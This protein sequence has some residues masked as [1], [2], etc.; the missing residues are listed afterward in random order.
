[1][2]YRQVFAR[3]IISNKNCLKQLYTKSSDGHSYMELVQ[4]KEKKKRHWVKG[5][6]LSFTIITRMRTNQIQSE[7]APIFYP[8]T[9]TSLRELYLLFVE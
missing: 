7:H 5:S 3:I 1:M 6:T 8:C 9:E 2:V 4:K